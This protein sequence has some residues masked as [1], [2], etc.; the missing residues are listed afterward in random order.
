MPSLMTNVQKQQ[1]GPALA[2]AVNTLEAAN[3]LFK[4]EYSVSD[5]RNASVDG[6]RC[7]G[8]NYLSCLIAG[9][10]LKAS[11]LDKSIIPDYYNFNSSNKKEMDHYQDYAYQTRDGFVYYLSDSSTTSDWGMA[12]GDDSGS[13]SERRARVREYSFQR[14][15]MMVDVNGIKGPNMLGKD[16]FDIYVDSK[17]SVIL[18]GSAAEAKGMGN[19][20]P[21]WRTYCNENE[22]KSAMNCAGSIGDNGWK[23]VYPY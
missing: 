14:Y 8:Y 10:F 23:V 3:E 5:I 19:D 11:H 21:Y 4:A 22:V 17:G 6:V 13:E 20:T 2:K 12:G 7:D 15:E 1:V 16:L 9:G 18:T